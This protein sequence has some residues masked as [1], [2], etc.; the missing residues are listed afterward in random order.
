MFVRAAHAQD[1]LDD[2]LDVDTA[3]VAVGHNVV[4]VNIHSR[5]NFLDP[6]R[7]VIGDL[8]LFEEYCKQKN[9]KKKF[10]QFF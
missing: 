3:P 4:A 9:I 8:I 6:H 7:Q 5:L 1:V 10:L 2:K